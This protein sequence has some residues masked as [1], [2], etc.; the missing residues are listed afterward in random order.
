MTNTIAAHFGLRGN[1]TM[2]NTIAVHKETGEVHLNPDMSLLGLTKWYDFYKKVPSQKKYEVWWESDEG[3]ATE[4][5]M[6]VSW[7]EALPLLMDRYPDDQGAD[8]FYNDPDTGQEV[9]IG[10]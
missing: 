4:T 3:M 5:I 9:W 8:G 2:I 10:W 7:E 1:H 6:A